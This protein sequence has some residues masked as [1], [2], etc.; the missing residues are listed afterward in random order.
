[1]YELLT[2]NYVEDDDNTYR[3]DYS[4]EFIRWALTPPGF[5]P[6]WL[7]GIRDENKTLVACITGVPVTVLAEEHKLKMAEIN[8]LCVHKK[9]RE[10]KLAALLISEVTRRVNLRDKWQAVPFMLSRSILLARTYRLL[11][12]ELPISIDQSTPRNL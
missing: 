7:V 1:M 8:Y 6:D 3:F 4:R 9:E 10:S 2:N 5:R 12:P 11:S